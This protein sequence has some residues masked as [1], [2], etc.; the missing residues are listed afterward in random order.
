[1][2]LILIR[3]LLI[4]IK[5]NICIIKISAQ[6]INFSNNALRRI[7]IC[8]LFSRFRR[9]PYLRR[10]GAFA[11]VSGRRRRARTARPPPTCTRAHRRRRYPFDVLAAH[12]RSVV[13]HLSRRHQHTSRAL[14]ATRSQLSHEAQH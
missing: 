13:R 11:F 8:K 6:F 14:F 4:R 7:I 9:S 1:M 3:Q 2:D 5:S 12:R 10:R